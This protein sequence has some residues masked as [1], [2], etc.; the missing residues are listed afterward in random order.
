LFDTGG[1]VGPKSF[2]DDDEED[3]GEK[4]SQS[5]SSSECLEELAVETVNGIAWGLREDAGAGLAGDGEGGGGGT[6]GGGALML[7][8]YEV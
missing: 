5:G 3:A 2:K 6:G 7:H 8:H 1:G 4:R